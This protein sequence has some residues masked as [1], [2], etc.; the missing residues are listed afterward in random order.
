MILEKIVRSIFIHY[1]MLN[2]R[3]YTVLE[4]EIHANSVTKGSLGEFQNV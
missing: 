2:F 3:I 1:Q 4:G